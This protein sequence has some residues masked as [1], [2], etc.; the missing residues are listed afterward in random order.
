MSGLWGITAFFI[1]YSYLCQV[2]DDD[3]NCAGT[4]V[5]PSHGDMYE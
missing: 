1:N 2:S 4:G 5:D 3:D